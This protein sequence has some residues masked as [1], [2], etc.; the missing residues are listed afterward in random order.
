MICRRG[1]VTKPDVGAIKI[2]ENETRFEINSDVAQ[3]F[4]EAVKA[5]DENDV[6][7]EQMAGPPA[8]H[9]GGDKRGFKGK[10]LSKGPKREY[11]PLDKPKKSGSY[12]GA[13]ED[14][15]PYVDPD[16]PRFEKP[17]KK[18][19]PFGHK[20]KYDGTKVQKSSSPEYDRALAELLSK[21]K[22]AQAVRKKK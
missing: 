18:K 7:I 22:A 3:R 16:K 17:K 8:A 9:D 4:A 5:E 12:S 14:R 15:A 11:H 10:G 6:K 20:P 21:G 1:K 2:S 13:Y 19:K